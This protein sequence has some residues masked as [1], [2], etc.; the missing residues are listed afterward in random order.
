MMRLHFKKYSEQGQ[1]LLVLHGLFGSQSNWGGHC[2]QLAE[3]FSVIGVDLRNHGESGHDHEHNYQVMA[4]DISELMH[5]LSIDSAYFLGHSMGGK[6]AMELALTQPE[7]V[8]KLLV[9]DIAP[10][11]YTDKADDHMRVMA[12]MNA[13]NLAALSS[14]TEAEQKLAGYIDDEATR[15]FIV[16]NLVRSGD[17]G[18]AWRLNLPVIEAN[19]DRLREKPSSGT[20]FNKPT[21]FVKGELSP[22]VQSKHEAQILELFPN[23]GVK[24]ISEA[25]HWLHADKPQAFQKVAADFFSD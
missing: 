25:G 10:V 12:G 17:S 5:T 16:T 23:A 18:F 13:L 21:L 22:Y 4:Q 11:L 15:K 20:E 3:Q 19:Y 7:L 1:P 9:V 24:I 6:V 14:R 2:K 8:A